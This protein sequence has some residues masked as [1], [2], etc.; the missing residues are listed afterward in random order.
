MG[1]RPKTAI[2]YCEVLKDWFYNSDG[3]LFP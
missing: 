3:M 1:L 2:I